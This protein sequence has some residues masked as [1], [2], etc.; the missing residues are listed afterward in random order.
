MKHIFKYSFYLLI[1]SI[2]LLLS[3]CGN[4]PDDTAFLEELKSIENVLEVEKVEFT[5]EGTDNF[6]VQTY[7][8]RY[9]SDECEVEAYLSVPN[10]YLKSWWQSGF[11][12]Q[13]SRIHCLSC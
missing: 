9:Q 7:L 8:I 13:R 3:G 2:L 1:L 4:T 11:R 5:E 6:K 10:K 12:C